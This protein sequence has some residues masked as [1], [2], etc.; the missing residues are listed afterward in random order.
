M[1]IREIKAACDRVLADPELKISKSGQTYCNLGVINICALLGL[2]MFKGMRASQIYD[3]CVLNCTEVNMDYVI[4]HATK[5]GLYVSAYKYQKETEKA[6]GHVAIIYPEAGAYS[7]TYKRIVPKI[8]NIGK[9][10][11]VMRVSGAYK[12]KEFPKF[13]KLA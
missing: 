11:E 2:N 5:D 3:Y 13:F 4:E 1:D 6:S 7:T 8:A 10:N 9:T 12:L